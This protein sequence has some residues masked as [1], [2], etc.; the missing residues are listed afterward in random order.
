MFLVKKI[1]GGISGYWDGA[2]NALFAGLLFIVQF[3]V[4]DIKKKQVG[5][6]RTILYKL[7]ILPGKLLRQ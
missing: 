1:F 3:T 2:K 6:L 4:D 5:G 7:A